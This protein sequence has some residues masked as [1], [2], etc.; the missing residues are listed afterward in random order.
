MR[1]PLPVLAAAACAALCACGDAPDGPRTTAAFDLDADLSQPERFWEL[2]FPSDLRLRA[3]GT[4]DL[5]GY[6]VRQGSQL[7]EDLR[8]AAEAR[9]GWPVLPVAY[10]RFD[11]PL[12]PRVLADVI[13]AAADAPV[14]LVDVDPASPERG[15]LVPTVAVTLGVD[16]WA[17]SYLLAV[18]P[19]P[20]FVLVGGRRYAVVVRRSLGDAAG[21]DLG[22]PAALATLAHGATPEAARG[23]A[24]AAR[25]PAPPRTPPPPPPPL[26]P[27]HPPPA[28]PIQD[29]I[30]KKK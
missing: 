23:A 2:P 11:A 17:P 4:P 14:L 28:P 7:F 3:D 26:S 6:P 9:P 20:G 29:I 15:A 16:D 1:L 5:T 21:H 18:A 27:P 22:V 12:A 13:P 10:F 25:D 30:K 8:A 19:R 24:A